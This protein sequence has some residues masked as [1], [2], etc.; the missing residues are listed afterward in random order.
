MPATRYSVL[1]IK[2]QYWKILLSWYQ[3]HILTKIK[4][5]NKQVLIWHHN[6]MSII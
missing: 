5:S 6:S 3:L 1:Q 4:S 2:G